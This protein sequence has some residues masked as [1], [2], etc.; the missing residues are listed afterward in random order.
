MAIKAGLGADGAASPAGTRAL[1]GL[2]PSLAADARLSLTRER[3]QRPQARGAPRAPQLRRVWPRGRAR[4]DGERQQV[5]PGRTAADS[6]FGS[7]PRSPSLAPRRRPLAAAGHRSC[8]PERGSGCLK[9]S[10]WLLRRGHLALLALLRLGSAAGAPAWAQVLRSPLASLGARFDAGAAATC[11]RGELAGTEPRAARR[12]GELG[13][14]RQGASSCAP[15]ARPRRAAALL[16]FAAILVKK[17]LAF[18]FEKRWPE[19]VVGSFLKRR[20]KELLEG[21]SASPPHICRVPN[22][23]G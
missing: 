7:P 12:H 11:P 5:G 23:P 20:G 3:R 6:G 2:R 19:L 22:S 13:K 18:F 14:C 17:S 21:G 1:H 16:G 8:S 4:R 15:S 10:P 9:T